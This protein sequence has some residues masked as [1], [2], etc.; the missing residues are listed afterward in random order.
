ME[1]QLLSDSVNIDHGVLKDVVFRSST[2][3]SSKSDNIPNTSLSWKGDH[4]ENDLAG[5]PAAQGV[6]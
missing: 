4:D 1:R 5:E 3:I 6:Q 2:V